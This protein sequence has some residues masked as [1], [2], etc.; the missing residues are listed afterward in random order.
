MAVEPE[1]D[2]GERAAWMSRGTRV[3]VLAAC[4]LLLG[5]VAL[6]GSFAAEPGR[7]VAVAGTGR[8]AL[9]PAADSCGAAATETSLTPSSSDSGPAVQRIKQR[10]KLIAG[11]DTNSYLWGFRNPNSGSLQGF[12]IDLVHALAK[13]ILGDPNAV[14]FL[15]VPT[16]NRIS[17]L[18]SGQ[19]DV[20]VRTMTITCAR[21]KLVSFSVPYFFAGQEVVAPKSSGITGFD[22]SLTGKKVCAA[23]G[24]TAA[25]MVKASSHG[26]T[27]FPVANQLDCLV[28]MQLGN[29]D[30]TI[31]DNALG[32][33]QVAQDPTVQLVGGALDSEPYGVAMKLGSDDLVRRVNAVLK[34]F[35][36]NQWQNEYNTWLKPLGPSPSAPVPRFAN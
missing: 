29:V 15:A 14:E 30:A 33:G 6:P 3:A 9:A 2:N 27:V 18:Q 23:T 34:D 17:A 26:A 7:G 22:S 32:A 4:A 13:S 36:A 11:I 20:V 21:M 19:V 8:V 12:D 24:S 35:L 10:G 1:V 28:Q 31:T 5:A 16:A 25:D